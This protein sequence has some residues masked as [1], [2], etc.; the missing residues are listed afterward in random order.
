VIHACRKL[1]GSLALAFLLAVGA[2]AIWAVFWFWSRATIEELGRGDVIFEDI[3]FAV[4]GTPLIR[5]YMSGSVSTDSYRTLDG[6]PFDRQRLSSGLR[7]ASLAGPPRQPFRGLSWED[8]IVGY[9]DEAEAP[10]WWYFVHDGQAQGSGYFVGYHAR[11]KALVG[12][13]GRTGFQTERPAVADWF[14]VVARSGSLGAMLPDG[15]PA[16]YGSPHYRGTAGAIYVAS[17]D[18]IYEVDLA[19]RT[20]KVVGEVPGLLAIGKTNEALPIPPDEPE[21]K[22]RPRIVTR[23]AP[24]SYL[25]ARTQDALVMI[26]PETKA[27]TVYAL[28]AELRSTKLGACDHLAPDTIVVHVQG[29]ARGHV[30]PHRLL[31]LKTNGQVVREESVKLLSGA[32]SVDQAEEEGSEWVA[33]MAGIPMPLFSVLAVTTLMPLDLLETGETATY[34]EAFRRSLAEGW[35]AC[36]VTGVLAAALAYLSLRRQRRYAQSHGVAWAVFVFLLGPA[37]FVGYLV[38]RAWP[39]CEPCPACRRSVPRDRESC[40]ACGRDF[41][42]PERRGTEVFAA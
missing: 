38:H 19:K 26:D 15:Y 30:Q 20:L 11:S 40:V 37:G 2:N 1:L 3:T 42:E 8:R 7:E 14:P 39:P 24:V 17:P 23:F 35:P 9:S 25:A 5:R 10:T 22:T 12:Y 21:T 41:P 36:L 18:L 4:D 32:V 13:L 6:R 16:R 33:A 27:Q 31:W 29:R 28:P 34:G